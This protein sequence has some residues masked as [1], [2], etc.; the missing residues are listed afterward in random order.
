MAL[1]GLSIPDLQIVK[2]LSLSSSVRVLKYSSSKEE[3]IIFPGLLVL[4]SLILATALSM[5]PAA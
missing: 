2:S 4:I 5:S 1:S 3:A